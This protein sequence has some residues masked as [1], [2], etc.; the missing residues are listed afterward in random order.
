M[1]AMEYYVMRSEEGHTMWLASDERTWTRH[2]D[3]GA[4]FTDATLA[5]DI[6]KRQLSDEQTFYVMGCMPTMCDDEGP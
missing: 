3:E 4:A 2:F 6:A 5:N 1:D